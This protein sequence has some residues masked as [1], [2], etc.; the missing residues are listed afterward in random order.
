MTQV[1]MTRVG[2]QALREELKRLRNEDRPRLA[3]AIG[4]A[5]EHGDLREN[6]EYHAAK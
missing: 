3:R 5:R 4:E 1:P 2:E 6:A